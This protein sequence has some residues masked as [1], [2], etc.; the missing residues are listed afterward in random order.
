MVHGA[1]PEDPDFARLIALELLG[2]YAAETKTSPTG[3]NYASLLEWYKH[4][5]NTRHGNHRLFEGHLPSLFSFSYVAHVVML[6]KDWDWLPDDDK[7]KLLA[8]L[9]SE[10]C[11][12]LV[13]D[14]SEVYANHPKRHPSPACLFLL[15][16][17][18]SSL[19][20]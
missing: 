4:K 11:I 9:R 7:G 20:P 3:I 19:P 6:Q 2:K 8:H 18:R 5:S 12:H 17:V 14:E 15:L 16:I 10:R 13:A 1:K